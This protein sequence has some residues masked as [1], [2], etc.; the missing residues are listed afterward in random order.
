MR[1]QEKRRQRLCALGTSAAQV[2]RIHGPVGMA[3]GA[4]N[5][6][7]I[8]IAILAEIVQAW[9]TRRSA[10][11]AGVLLA[12]G[13]S[14]RM[15]ANKLTLPYRGKPLVRHAAEAALAAG[16]SP[17]IVV[18]GHQPDLI[19]QAL[20]GLDVRFV[21][22]ALYSDGLSTSLKA[23]LSAIPE[24]KDGAMILLGDMPHVSSR[25]LAQLLEAFAPAKDRSIC[26]PAFEGTR[27][28]PVL[29]AKRYFPEIAQLTG[30]AGAKTLMSLYPDQVHEVAAQD[31][32]P[33]IDIDTPETLT[34]ACNRR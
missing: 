29:W 31:N 13:L 3:I 25:L 23:G 9:R 27:G 5:P 11:F 21:H 1:T 14:T 15:A 20:T 34:A 16:L 12:G 4:R 22:N 2:A 33:L 8:A 18:T 10:R 28:N 32:S 6:V 17:L 19:H 30:D 7:E 26:V 24:D